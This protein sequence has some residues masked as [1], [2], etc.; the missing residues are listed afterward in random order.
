M[1]ERNEIS[2]EG[3]RYMCQIELD[4]QIEVMIN[5]HMYIS[6]GRAFISNKFWPVRVLSLCVLSIM[7]LCVRSKSMKMES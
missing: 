2:T 7:Y 4:V 5:L 6:R 3:K 1:A